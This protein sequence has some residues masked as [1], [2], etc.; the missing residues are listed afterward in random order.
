MAKKYSRQRTR[1][2]A[3]CRLEDRRLLSG[4]SATW[5]GQDGQDYVGPY[6]GQVPDGVQD[7]RIGLAN[8]PADR[9][10]VSAELDGFGGGQW[11]YQGPYGPWSAALVRATGATTGDLYIEPDRAETGR[12]FNLI[13]NF[14]DG[15][16]GR[17][18]VRRRHGRPEP[19]DADRPP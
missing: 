1:I 11:V 15:S 4:P 14:D 7:V 10:I 18:L 12:P 17:S 19:A 2:S 13:L 9:M 6:P 3:P 16:Q 8:L 5:I